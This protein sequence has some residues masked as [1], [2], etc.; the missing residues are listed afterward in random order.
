MTPVQAALEQTAAQFLH[1]L[2]YNIVQDIIHSP[3]MKFCHV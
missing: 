3:G 2:N 1:M